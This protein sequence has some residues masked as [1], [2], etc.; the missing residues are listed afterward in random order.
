MVGGEG[1]SRDVKDGADQADGNGELNI[2]YCESSYVFIMPGLVFGSLTNPK[3]MLN[4]A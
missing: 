2:S 3:I 4:I 1:T